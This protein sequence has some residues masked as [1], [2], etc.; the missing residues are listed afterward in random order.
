MSSV[1]ANVLQPGFGSL[2]LTIPSM[3]LALAVIILL[4]MVASYFMAGAKKGRMPPIINKPG[5]FQLKIQKQFEFVFKGRELYERAKKESPGSPI[6]FLTNIGPMTVLPNDRA[7]EIRHH[8][9]LSFR[10]AFENLIPIG[11]PGSRVMGVLNHPD[12]IM[13]NVVK[14]H[15]INRLDSITTP[16]VLEADYAVEKNFGNSPEWTE[17]SIAKNTTDMVARLVSRIFLGPK[18][19]RSEEWIDVTVNYS[20][21]AT[22]MLKT[23]RTLPIWLRRFVYWFSQP[24]K[25]YRRLYRKAEKLVSGLSEER[26]KEQQDYARRGEVPPSYNDAIEWIDKEPRKSPVV[27]TDFQLSL[28]VSSVHT[29][30][31]L[32]TQVM[33]QLAT[34]PEV[35]DA[36]RAEIL[37]VLPV[38]GFSKIGFNSLKL[39][40]SA[41]KE[42]QRI[43]PL[44]TANMQRM[45]KKDTEL[46]DGTFLPKGEMVAVEAAA[47]LRDPSKY[48]DPDKFDAWRFYR[49][50]QQPGNEAT[51]QLVSITSDHLV[52][53]YGTYVCQG[54]FFAGHQI[55]IALCHLL[56]KYDWKLAEG[57]TIAPKWIGIDPITDSSVRLMCRRRKEELDLCTLA[58]E[59]K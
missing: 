1:A 49:M 3:T 11:A 23:L 56:L 14:K 16:L 48:P 41:I 9:N 33:L 43:K 21:A 40:D 58:T 10:A 32:F 17:C 26:R 53:G 52:F 57:A 2:E 19:S 47:K 25:N 37:E 28:S 31:D 24:G 38:H 35:V 15:L 42:A 7:T 20:I 18:L 22:I 50:R 4:P 12:R 51:A 34:H 44:M 8:P 59:E 45:V 29:T 13:Q 39:L 27:V 6:K 5:P 54:R 36:L 55:K 30:A 46:S